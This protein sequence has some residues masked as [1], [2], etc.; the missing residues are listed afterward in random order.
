MWDVP[1]KPIMAIVYCL[2]LTWEMPP[3]A[4][5][6]KSFDVGEEKEAA[7]AY[8]NGQI[9]WNKGACGENHGKKS[10]SL[11]LLHRCGNETHWVEITCHRAHTQVADWEFELEPNL[12]DSSPLS[13]LF[14]I[15]IDEWQ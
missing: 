3:D 9:L 4:T 13:S 11:F 10:V 2:V 14:V 5:I 7:V 1:I 12:P 8:D 6:Y 15:T